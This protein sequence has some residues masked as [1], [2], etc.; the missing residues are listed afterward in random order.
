MHLFVDTTRFCYFIP[1]ILYSCRVMHSSWNERTW[2]LENGEDFSFQIDPFWSSERFPK[3][4]QR[5]VPFLHSFFPVSESTENENSILITLLE[6]TS[7]LR[8]ANFKSP[9]SVQLSW[10]GEASV[11][12]SCHSSATQ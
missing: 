11:N 4:T 10:F 7:S 6:G 8:L 5:C 12:S 1:K 3:C 9:T 2:K